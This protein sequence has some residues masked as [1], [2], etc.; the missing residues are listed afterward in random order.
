[1]QLLAQ[2]EVHLHVSQNI[3]ASEFMPDFLQ[4]KRSRYVHYPTFQQQAWLAAGANHFRPL[5][6]T[7]K[8]ITKRETFEFHCLSRP[9]DGHHPHPWDQAHADY[10]YE[11][12]ERH[13]SGISGREQ[14]FFPKEKQQ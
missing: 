12:I 2:N 8:W 10:A 14:E 6:S 13:F 4:V 9:R 1:M 5:A 3:P 7:K 11:L